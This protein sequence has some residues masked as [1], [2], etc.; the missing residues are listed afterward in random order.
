MALNFNGNAAARVQYANVSAWDQP[1]E[2]TV[3]AW[4][5]KETVSSGND[6]ASIVF[7]GPTNLA[8][9]RLKL[10]SATDFSLDVTRSGSN[11]DQSVS[12]S[13]PIVNNAWN[14]CVG[15]YRESDA[16]STYVY[17]GT[18]TSAPSAPTQTHTDDGGTRSTD[19]GNPICVGNF[20]SNQD[21][22]FPGA[23]AC[24]GIENQVLTLQQLT[25]IWRRLG[26][27]L[28]SRVAYSHLWNTSLAP[29]Y[30]GVGGNGTI[31]NCA[32]HSHVPVGPIF[33]W[34]SGWQGAFTAAAAPAVTARKNLMLLGVGA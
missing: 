28:G 18:L 6:T 11:L 12:T 3:W 8:V 14:F 5:Y 32:L 7:H 16:T 24:W 21:R 31:S 23:I 30:S 19:S 2:F 15:T 9:W 29:D 1:A 27:N 13:A 10:A 17:H 25:Q 22:S 20:Y 33:G 26:K 4:V 34:S